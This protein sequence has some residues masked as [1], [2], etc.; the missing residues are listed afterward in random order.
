LRVW[1]PSN[2]VLFRHP[3]STSDQETTS[4]PNSSIQH[5][6]SKRP[7]AVPRRQRWGRS[8]FEVMDAWVRFFLG[9]AA[10]FFF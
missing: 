7:S 8:W 4:S 9:Y 1:S 3:P 10:R 6:V 5:R 2:H